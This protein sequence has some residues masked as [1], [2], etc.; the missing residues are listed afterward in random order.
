MQGTAN[1]GTAQLADQATRK[2]LLINQGKSPL[3]ADA[4]GAGI[5]QWSETAMERNGQ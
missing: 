1:G 2:V 3:G 4:A 5:I